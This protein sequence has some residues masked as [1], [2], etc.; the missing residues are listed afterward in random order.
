MIYIWRKMTKIKML[1]LLIVL[2]RYFAATNLFNC[3]LDFF[4]V[5]VFHTSYK[6]TEQFLLLNEERIKK[7]MKGFA[8]RKSCEVYQNIWKYR[9]THHRGYLKGIVDKKQYFDKELIRLR[10]KEGFIDCGAYH[11]DTIKKFCENIPEKDKYN[12]I[13]AFEPDEY[14]FKMLRRYVEKSK[15]RNIKC[16]QIG[17]WDS[18]TILRFQGNTEEGCKVATDGDMMIHAG[19]IDE[20]AGEAWG[21]VTYIKMDVEGAELKSLMGAKNVIRNYH[22]RLAISIY[23]SDEDMIGIIEY[24]KEN[25]PFY[26]LYVRHYTYFYADTVLYAIDEQKKYK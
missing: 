20:F 7:V 23:H 1:H 12:F 8:D 11:G 5:H 10:N 15:K 14:N 2:I 22:P 16:Y 17:T 26:K 18:N 9:A 13:A 24:V 3:V 25:Y 21:G 4:E 19:T 6:E